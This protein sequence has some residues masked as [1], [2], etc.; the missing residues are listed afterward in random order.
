M[1]KT[2]AIIIGLVI[3]GG[4][5]YVYTGSKENPIAQEKQN[6][7]GVAQIADGTYR[8]DPAQSDFNWSGKKPLIQGYI[9]SGTIDITEGLITVSGDSI[10]GEFTL[11]MN[12]L[13]VGLTAKK[14]GQEG[15]LEGHLKGERFFDVSKYPQASFKIKKAT[16]GEAT[17][18]GFQYTVTG[19]LTMKGVTHE[20]SFP[21]T[22]YFASGALQAQADA[23]IDRTKWGITAG[24]GNFFENLGDNMIDD[25]VAISFS[26][27]A[28]QVQP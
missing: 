7:A 17:A 3:V 4:F 22:V 28:P 20:I 5:L 10:S 21:A 13:H 6:L 16:K 23:E 1:K 15:N 11:D 12:T 18:A 25:M 14:P 2:I 19:D 26:I 9:N 8:L 27:V 24:S